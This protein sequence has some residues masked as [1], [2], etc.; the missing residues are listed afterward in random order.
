VSNGTE[1][2]FPE[3]YEAG[4][5]SLSSF[6]THPARIEPVNLRVSIPE[7]VTSASS[8]SARSRSNTASRLARSPHRLVQA[9]HV[10]RRAA[11][12]TATRARL[13]APLSA[14]GPLLPLMG[15]RAPIR[16]TFG[17][18]A[19]STQS[20]CATWCD[21]ERMELLLQAQCSR[22]AACRGSST[23]V[24]RS[25]HSSVLGFDDLNAEAQRQ[26]VK[27]TYDEAFPKMLAMGWRMSAGSFVGYLEAELRSGFVSEVSCVRSKA[28]PTHC[29]RP[30]ARGHSTTALASP[31]RQP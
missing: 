19:T 12:I 2:L 16:Q 22:S 13:A 23:Q 29:A 1:A 20:T 31:A 14:H 5:A 15:G 3:R 24:T 17:R 7:V 6:N 9:S 10:A 25:K 28:M 30:A 4:T 11:I 26:L 27:R 21:R 18:A 8:K